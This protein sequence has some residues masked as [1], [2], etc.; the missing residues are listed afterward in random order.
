MEPA[1]V[2]TSIILSVGTHL[3]DKTSVESIPCAIFVS[4]IY[5][6]VM[7]PLLFNIMNK[8]CSQNKPL[9]PKFSLELFVFL[10]FFSSKTQNP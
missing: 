10:F 4:K 3:A 1:Y 9:L 5:S 6:F 2:K 7:S 8:Y